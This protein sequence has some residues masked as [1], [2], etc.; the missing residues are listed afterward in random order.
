MSQVNNLTAVISP[1]VTSITATLDPAIIEKA[2]LNLFELAQQKGF[3]GTFEDFLQS[4]AG[5]QDKH[6]SYLQ[7]TPSEAWTINHNLGVYPTVQVLTMGGIEVYAEVIHSSVNQ[8]IVYFDSPTT[9]QVIC[10]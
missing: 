4:I 8:F 3:V 2:K 7:S 1:Q 10:N 5:S 9:G 6:F